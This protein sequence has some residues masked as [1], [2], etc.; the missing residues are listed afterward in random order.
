ME[1]GPSQIVEALVYWLLPPTCREEV[2]GDMRERHQNSIQFLVEAISTVPHV[3][4]GRIRRTTDPC[5]GFDGGGFDL[6][7]VRDDGA[8]ARQ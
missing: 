8:V 5:R 1:S 4:Y 7:G 3:I 2:L 6:Y